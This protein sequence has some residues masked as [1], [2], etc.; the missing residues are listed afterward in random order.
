MHLKFGPRRFS[1]VLV[2]ATTLALW[3]CAGPTKTRP[4]L[5]ENTAA[6]QH[7]LAAVAFKYG[8]KDEAVKY[9]EQALTLDP[10]H[11][12]SLFLLASLRL[13]KKEYSAAEELLLKNLALKHDD[14]ETNTRLGMGYARARA[15]AKGE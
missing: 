8:L 11:Q 12:P 3:G 15:P 13:D 6:Y 10:N 4:K 1:W 14:A 5:D 9:L 2:A 7:N